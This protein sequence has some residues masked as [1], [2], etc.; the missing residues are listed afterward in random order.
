MSENSGSKLDSILNSLN[1]NKYFAGIMMI[2]LNIGSKYVSLEISD[3]QNALLSNK[4]IRRLLIFTIVFIATRDVKVSLIITAVFIVLVLELFN[5]KSNM[6]ILP[7]NLKKYDLNKDGK[8]S[9]DEIRKAY[10][11][12]QKAGKIKSNGNQ[13]Q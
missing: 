7:E 8:I 2:L 9:E 13:Q 6:C 10:E 11:T 3:N 5:E 1:G 4:I 12:L